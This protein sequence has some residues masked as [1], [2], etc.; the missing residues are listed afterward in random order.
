MSTT[1]GH[2]KPM[3]IKGENKRKNSY[4][5][6]NATVTR[7]T[8]TI[9]LKFILESTKLN[10]LEDECILAG[11]RNSECHSNLS[12]QIIYSQNNSRMIRDH[13]FRRFRCYLLNYNID[14]E[15]IDVRSMLTLV[16][17]RI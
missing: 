13:L 2:V 12:N 9:C 15:V 10:E 5:L 16:L 6:E 8:K 4:S 1:S 17:S 7:P 11:S 14:F 3:E